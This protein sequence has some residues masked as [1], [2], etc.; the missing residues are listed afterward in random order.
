[1]ANGVGSSAR[2][3]TTGGGVTVVVDVEP[4]MVTIDVE[5][6]VTAGGCTVVVDVAVIAGVT[7]LQ[8]SISRNLQDMSEQNLCSP[9]CSYSRSE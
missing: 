2:F 8:S 7:V 1:M 6:E 9:R 4:G 5:V 3:T